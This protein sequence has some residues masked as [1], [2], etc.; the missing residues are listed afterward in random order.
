MKNKARVIYLDI[1][2]AIRPVPHNNDIPI[3]M[4]L[5]NLDSSSES[6]Y[7][8]EINDDHWNIFPMKIKDILN[9]LINMI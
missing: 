9:Y 7:E 5:D 8:H 1:P 2:S 3:P 6:D 4:A